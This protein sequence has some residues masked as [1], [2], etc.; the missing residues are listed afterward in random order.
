MKTNVEIKINQC[1]SCPFAHQVISD[2]SLFYLDYVKYDKK[3]PYDK[4]FKSEVRNIS[5]MFNFKG[6]FDEQLSFILNLSEKKTNRD[7]DK[8]LDIEYVD[9]VENLHRIIKSVAVLFN[10]SSDGEFY[11]EDWQK[12][13]VEVIGKIKSLLEDDE[14]YCSDKCINAAWSRIKKLKDHYDN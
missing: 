11:I 12:Y 6:N 3:K 2:Y 13:T 10:D 5:E 7:I 4:D 14:S 9:C 8:K 1:M